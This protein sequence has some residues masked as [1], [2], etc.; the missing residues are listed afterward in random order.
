MSA[1]DALRNGDLSKALADL[2]SEV[3]AAPDDPRHRVFLFQL[4]SVL[5]QWDRA[6]AQLDVVLSLDPAAV[7]MVKTYEAV[8]QCEVYRQGVFAGERSPLILGEAEPWVAEMVEAVRLSAKGDHEAARRLREHAYE[9]APP[10]A[11]SLSSADDPGNSGGAKETSFEWVADA[12]SRLGPLLEVIVNG[13]YYWLPFRRVRQINIDPP[14]D[15]RD[16][17]WLP[18]RFLLA[19]EGET[20]GMIPTR[21]AGS[22]TREDG[23]I[24]LGRKTEW[25]EPIAGAFEGLG[26]RIL[27]TDQGEYGLT[28]LRQLSF[29]G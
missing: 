28:S 10:S 11:G 23:Q 12:D 18:A 7:A 3:R 4:L 19:N 27:T 14:E 8:L 2:Q 20:V 21:Y 25:L 16:L 22:E 17:V 1:I 26:Q 6:L 13:R 5:G 9:S 24:R 29:A 15:L